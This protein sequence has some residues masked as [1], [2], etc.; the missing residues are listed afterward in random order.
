VQY[1]LLPLDFVVCSVT[2]HKR[3]VKENFLNVWPT[4]V[5]NFYKKV[6]FFSA[7]MGKFYSFKNYSEALG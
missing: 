5:P 3:E 4:L 7:R 1:L 2:Y 6:P